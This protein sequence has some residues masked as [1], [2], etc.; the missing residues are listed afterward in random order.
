MSSRLMIAT[1]AACASIMASV[2]YPQTA[3]KQSYPSAPAGT[4]QSVGTSNQSGP[5]APSGGM[6]D[7]RNAARST[8]TR[9]CTFGPQCDVFFGN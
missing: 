9:S 7:P 1:A 3:P 5:A 2:A 8:P 4:Q 6:S